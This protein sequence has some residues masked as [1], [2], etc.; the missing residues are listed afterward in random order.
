MNK[1]NK[2]GGFTLIELL[3]VIAIIA[4]LAAIVIVA[5]NPGHQLAQSRNAQRWSNVNTILNA[6]HQYA[7]ENSGALPSNLTTSIQEICVGGTATST[8]TGASLTPLNE[9]IWGEKFV[10]SIPAD[11]SCPSACATNGV[12]YTIVKSANGRITVAAPDAEVDEV[13][14]ASR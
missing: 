5:I 10:V 3:I 13:I 7:V 1:R 2:K 6:V 8:C 11:P 9:L 14:S 4:I 12:G